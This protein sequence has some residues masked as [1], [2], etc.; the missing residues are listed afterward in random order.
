MHRPL[1][2]VLIGKSTVNNPFLGLGELQSTA[3]QI[4]RLSSSIRMGGRRGRYRRGAAPI[5]GSVLGGSQTASN[6]AMQ[7]Q[8]CPPPPPAP[9]CPCSHDV[10]GNKVPWRREGMQKIHSLSPRRQAMRVLDERR[11]RSWST[12]LCGRGAYLDDD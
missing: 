5:G 7:M 3:E 1:E 2:V 11:G 4:R 8:F 6:K 10:A 9:C 12:K